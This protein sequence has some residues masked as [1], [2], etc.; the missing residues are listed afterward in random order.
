MSVLCFLCLDILKRFKPSSSSADDTDY[1]SLKNSIR[2]EDVM[3]RKSSSE[4]ESDGEFKPHDKYEMYH[5]IDLNSSKTDEHFHPEISLQQQPTILSRTP[6]PV[7][8]TTQIPKI[9]LTPRIDNVRKLIESNMMNIF[10]KKQHYE[11]AN[12]TISFQKTNRN[13][14]DYIPQDDDRELKVDMKILA[15]NEWMSDIIDLYDSI[16]IQLNEDNQNNVTEEALKI[17]ESFA[18]WSDIDNIDKILDDFH[19]SDI[20]KDLPRF[21]IGSDKK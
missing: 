1:L 3:E 17:Y 15:I 6:S 11:E 18:N 2:I 8:I 20:V 12:S 5:E 10:L 13:E 14:D 21:L 4:S 9:D 16:V 7:K 19:D